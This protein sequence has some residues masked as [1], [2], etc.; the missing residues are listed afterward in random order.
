MIVLDDRARMESLAALQ[1]GAGPSRG[2]TTML[3]SVGLAGTEIAVAA[4]LLR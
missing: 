2:G 4:T 1:A 3:C